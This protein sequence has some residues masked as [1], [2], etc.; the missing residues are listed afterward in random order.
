[1]KKKLILTTTKMKKMKKMNDVDDDWIEEQSKREELLEDEDAVC[2]EDVSEN[3][4]KDEGDDFYV[5]EESVKEE[6]FKDEDTLSDDEDED[7]QKDEEVDLYVEEES[8]KEELSEDEDAL[9][10]DEGGSEEKI[11]DGS[12]NEKE[13][14]KEKDK[15]ITVNESDTEDIIDLSETEEEK[16]EKEKGSKGER[17]VFERPL[18]PLSRR[19]TDGNILES[20]KVVEKLERAQTAQEKL[21]SPSPPTTSRVNKKKRF[22]NRKIK[23][24][25]TEANYE[26]ESDNSVNKVRPKSSSGN[27]STARCNSTHK[28]IG[29]QV[30]E[31]DFIRP[32]LPLQKEHTFVETSNREEILLKDDNRPI[33]APPKF[34]R[35]P[36]EAKQKEGR[37]PSR[38]SSAR[39]SS[40]EWILKE[41]ATRPCSSPVRSDRHYQVSPLRAISVLND[42]QERPLSSGRPP[43]AP[44]D[45]TKY[46]PSNAIREADEND[47][48]R[49]TESPTPPAQDGDY[50]K[51]I[52]E[53]NES[54]DDEEE[55]LSG[56]YLKI[57]DDWLTSLK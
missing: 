3:D 43:S 47:T 10:N 5:E 39:L 25:Q 14:I 27:I 32:L 7:D 35:H 12:L 31:D 20:R 13:E 55:E 37:A 15:K 6:L 30:N 46:N 50:D 18:G 44:V 34:Q 4:Q 45:E 48:C 51:N 23:R 22:E 52:Q 40:R 2:E 41:D 26:A 17:Q 24:R 19:Q 1:M 36:V 54:E 38:V 11:E 33:T 9:S 28:E 56:N 49:R 21:P 8:A 29:R 53:E 42:L 57:V 16:F